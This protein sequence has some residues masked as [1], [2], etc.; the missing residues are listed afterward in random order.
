MFAW[1]KR[2]AQDEEPLVPHGLVGQATESPEPPEEPKTESRP[3]P[4]QVPDQHPQA[5][6]PP[7]DQHSKKAPSWLP[8]PLPT[9]TS[10]TPEPSGTTQPLPAVENA[11]VTLE[12]AVGDTRKQ[13]PNEYRR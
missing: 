8:L 2:R 1:R 7:E 6:D 9:P 12:K 3:G 10:V 4:V 5:K 13:Q 11:K